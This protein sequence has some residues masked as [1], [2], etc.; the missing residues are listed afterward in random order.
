MCRKLIFLIYFVL[1]LSI[2]GN[3][4]AALVAHLPFDEGSGTVAQDV[5]GNEHDGTLTEEG[6]VWAEGPVAQIVGDRSFC[7]ECYR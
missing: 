6:V 5:T 7:Y 2:A 4:S 3:A 1:V